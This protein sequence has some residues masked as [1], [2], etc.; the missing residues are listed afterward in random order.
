MILTYGYKLPL[1]VFQLFVSLDVIE[2]CTVRHTQGLGL[3]GVKYNINQ[4]SRVEKE[5]ILS[6]KPS[7]LMDCEKMYSTR[8]WKYSFESSFT[9]MSLIMSVW[10][11]EESSNL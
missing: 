11:I 6:I 9:R 10:V 1:N 8:T 4:L 3:T 2:F 7:I 5:C